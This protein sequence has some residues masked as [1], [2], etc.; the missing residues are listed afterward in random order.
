[1]HARESASFWRE[2]LVT[3]FIVLR[4][5]AGCRSGGNKLSNVR[6]VQMA[7]CRNPK[8]PWKLETGIID[9]LKKPER[10]KNSFFSYFPLFS[11]TI[12]P[13]SAFIT[14]RAHLAAAAGITVLFNKTG[15]RMEREQEVSFSRSPTIH[16]QCN[17]Y[18]RNCLW[19]RLEREK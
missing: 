11:L 6:I 13:Q 10:S 19:K 8:R 2:N 9:E 7:Y 15:G 12:S 3:V 4:V 18:K 5:L 17:R 14:H 1:M 16:D